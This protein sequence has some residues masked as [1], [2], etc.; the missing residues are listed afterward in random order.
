ME[1]KTK[2]VKAVKD[3]FFTLALAVTFIGFSAFKLAETK[4]SLDD[5]IWFMFD[6][7][8]NPGEPGY[9]E[10][11]L[12]PTNYSSTGSASAPTSCQ[13]GAKV[14]AVRTTAAAHDDQIPD[15]SA[16]TNLESE[17][18]SSSPDPNLVRQKQA[19]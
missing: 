6:S 9:E 4:P 13:P 8:I 7:E 10:A 11:L 5:E 14:C 18:T 17:L 2:L 1:T 19:D 3:Y 16:L 12:E 15:Q